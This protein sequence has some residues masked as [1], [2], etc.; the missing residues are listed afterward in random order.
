MSRPGPLDNK[1]YLCPHGKIGYSSAELT[2]EPFL[3]ISKNLSGRLI[4]H[5]GGGPEITSL[6]HCPKCQAH[7]LAYN[8]RKQAEYEMVTRYDT[9]DTGEGQG[10]YLVDADWVENWKRYVKSE[11]VVHYADSTTGS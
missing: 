3:P 4:S 5:Y 9:K 1:E 11:P 8:L 7:I 2:A 6:E 10:W